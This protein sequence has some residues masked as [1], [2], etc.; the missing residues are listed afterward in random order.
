MLIYLGELGGSKELNT[1]KTLEYKNPWSLI[2]GPKMKIFVEIKHNDGS[3]SYKNHPLPI[4]YFS[5]KKY[6][7]NDPIFEKNRRRKN[8]EF[9]VVLENAFEVMGEHAKNGFRNL[10]RYEQD[11]TI[12]RRKNQVLK[13]LREHGNFYED[14][15][16]GLSQEVNLRVDEVY[17]PNR[18]WARKEPT[19]GIN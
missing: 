14:E 3:I 4:L 16:F 13:A 7:R 15:L 9:F 8:Q 17:F 1:L 11:E 19:I 2:F 10:P 5:P 12:R 18:K 6:A